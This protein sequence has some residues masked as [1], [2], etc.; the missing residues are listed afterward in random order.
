[1]RFTNP[2]RIQTIA[3]LLGLLF[4]FSDLGTAQSLISK[5]SLGSAY[6]PLD[7]WA[8]PVVDRAIARGAIPSQFT[9]I[10]P[11]TR[12]AIADLLEQRR[13]QP[14]KYASDDESLRLV[15]ALDK[16]FRY[17]LTVIEGES[18]SDA[19]LTSV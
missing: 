17:E 2:R 8:Y 13:R 11:W 18:V 7:H 4:T 3:I 9:G 14:G 15:A 12:M 19:Q 10:R 1:M 6:L 16:E 5:R